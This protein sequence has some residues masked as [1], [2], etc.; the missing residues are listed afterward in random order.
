MDCYRLE[1]GRYVLLRGESPEK[2][3][4]VFDMVPEVV[5]EDGK[6]VIKEKQGDT[7]SFASIA[8]A[9]LIE[10]KTRVTHGCSEA[11]QEWLKAH[12]EFSEK[13]AALHSCP[14][15]T[16]AEEINKALSAPEYLAQIV[17]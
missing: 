5:N 11:M 13:K 16:P 4:P 12:N 8:V 3:T 1:N 17:G 10:G 2:A 6:E 15:E 14:P 9:Y 7:I